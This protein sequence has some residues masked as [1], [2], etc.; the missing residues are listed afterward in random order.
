MKGMVVRKDRGYTHKP[1][2]TRKA[3]QIH[4][5]QA[6]VTFLKD[7]MTDGALNQGNKTKNRTVSHKIRLFSD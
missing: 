4:F 2:T 7:F 3:I 5:G 1:T 6:S